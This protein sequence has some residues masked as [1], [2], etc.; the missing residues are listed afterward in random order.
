MKIEFHISK[1]SPV[2]IPFANGRLHKELF[3]FLMFRFH[4]PKRIDADMKPV[5]Q[6]SLRNVA[7]DLK[8]FL[9]TIS[10]NRLNFELLRFEDLQRILN[11][12]QEEYCWTSDTYN[13]KYLRCRAFFDFLRMR[14][15]RH[16]VIFPPR[17]EVIRYFGD[18]DYALSAIKKEKT[19]LKDDSL[20]RSVK[21]DDY[22]E[23]VISMQTYAELYRR[24]SDIDPVYAVLAQVMMQ[25]CLRI[26]N[27]CQISISSD[28]LNPKWM[29]WPEFQAL[30]LEYLKF[31]HVAKG[32]KKTW[33]YVWPVT[34]RAIY[35]DYVRPY[36]HKRI[37]LYEDNYRQRRNASLQQ[38]TLHL[39][40]GILWLTATGVPVKPYMVEEAF[41]KTGLEVTPHYLRHTGATHL[42]WNYCELK[43]IEPDERMAV[44]FQSFLQF[45]LGHASVETTRCYI[46]T[47][48][49]KRA[50]TVVPFALPGNRCDLDELLPIEAVEEMKMLEFFSGATG[51]ISLNERLN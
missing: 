45:Q 22:V 10:A 34:L 26:G 28:R 5:T 15:V 40:K 7:Y 20:K 39:P 30:N 43:G 16:D 13:I 33:C 51:S 37:R 24:L 41:R 32:G 35:E 42:L 50:Q 49:R 11:A 9:E 23:R 27:A 17:R 38:G 3:E 48:V 21:V 14:G 29:L 19:Y 31:N 6:S 4:W 36:F 18:T 47:L 46:K 44:Q 8:Q 25:T 2:P 12:Q 1:K